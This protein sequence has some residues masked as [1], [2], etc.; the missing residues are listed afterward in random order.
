MPRHLEAYFMKLKQTSLNIFSNFVGRPNVVKRYFI[1]N[2]TTETITYYQNREDRSKQE[3]IYLRDITEIAKEK[4][5]RT[6]L[7]DSSQQ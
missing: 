2:L 5:I 6:K 4:K 3:I 7:F 1:F